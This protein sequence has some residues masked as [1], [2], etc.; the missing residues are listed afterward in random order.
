MIVKQFIADLADRGVQIHIDRNNLHVNAP[1]GVIN[2]KIKKQLLQYKH[3]IIEH[4]LLSQPHAYP[5]KR[6]THRYTAP[7]SYSQQRLWFI[8][9]KHEPDSSTYNMLAVLRIDGALNTAALSNAFL[10]L[11]SRHSSLRTTFALVDGKPMQRV[12]NH[13]F[14]EI[15]VIDIKDKQ[16]LYYL[17]AQYHHVFQLSKGPLIKVKLLRL[18]V[19]NYILLINIH[20]IICDGWSMGV[21]LHELSELYRSVI[22]MQPSSLARL[23][24]QYVDFS[25]WQRQYLQGKN[26]EQQLE[27]WKSQ[28]VG[29]PCVLELPTDKPRSGSHTSAGSSVNFHIAES[30]QSKLIQLSQ[31]YQCTLF[32]TLL[33]AFKLLLARYSG[34]NDICIGTPIANRQ[35][36][37][38]ENLIGFFTNTLVIRSKIRD[39]ISFIDLLHDL[40]KT[41]LN[42][43]SNQDVPFDQIVKAV[44]PN[45]NEHYSALF[46]VSFSLVNEPLDALSLPGCTISNV[47]SPATTSPFDLSITVT[48]SKNTLTGFAQYRSGLFYRSTIDQLLSCYTLLLDKIVQQ[49]LA[50]LADLSLLSWAD[51]QKITTQ[52]NRT[53][54]QANKTGIVHQWFEQ[55]VKHSP[56]ALAVTD[57]QQTINYQRLNETSNQLARYLLAHNTGSEVRVG[58]CLEN[59]VELIIAIIAI[60]KAGAVYVP[61]D[62]S[63][64]ENR[65]RYI[66]DDSNCRLFLTETSFEHLSTSMADIETIC[67]DVDW[68]LITTHSDNNPNQA[69]KPDNLAYIIY[70]SGSTG[71]PKGVMITQRAF[72][73]HI[74]WM[75]K[76]FSLD[77][78]DRVLQKTP[79]IFDAACSEW[80]ATLLSGAQLFMP[81]THVQKNPQQLLS[82]IHSNQISYLHI[83]PSLLALLINHTDCQKMRSLRVIEVGG[84]LFP[85]RVHENISRKLPDTMVYHVYG[86]TE[87]TIESTCWQCTDYTPPIAVPIG[88]ANDNVLIYILDNQQNLAPIGAKGQLYIGGEGLARGY[89]KKPDLTAE[90]FIPN[91]FGNQRGARLYKTGDFARY[92]DDGNIMFIGRADHQVQLRGL[93]IELGE[94]ENALLSHPMIEQA[95]VIFQADKTDTAKHQLNAF[96]TCADHHCL[97]SIALRE[98]LLG[99][100]PDYMLPNTFTFC[101]ELPRTT[102]G[103]IDRRAI[104]ENL[105]PNPTPQKNIP[106]LPMS[107][108][109]A[110][111]I[112][113]WQKAL[114]IDLEDINDNFFELGGH[115]LLAGQLV[116]CIN[117]SFGTSLSIRDLFKTPTIELLAIAIDKQ[118]VALS[119]NTSTV[120]YIEEALPRYSAMLSLPQQRVI[121]C[122]CKQPDQQS[123]WNIPWFLRLEGAINTALLEQSLQF[124]VL[125]HQ[126][127]RTAFQRREDSYS[128][129]IKDNATLPFCTIDIA[130]SDLFYYLTVLR[131]HLFDM[132]HAPLI[133]VVLL[134]LSKTTH[135]LSINMHHIIADGYSLAILFKELGALYN[136]GLN[137]QAIS[138]APLP[139]TYT[140]FT[141]WQ[142]RQIERGKTIEHMNY[143]REYLHQVNTNCTFTNRAIDQQSY[144]TPHFETCRLSFSTQLYNNLIQLSRAQHCTLFVSLITGFTLLLSQYS[145][146]EDVC[147]LFD[148]AN[149]QQRS[150]HNIIGFFANTLLLRT[151]ITNNSES[152]VELLRRV[153]STVLAISDHQ[154]IAFDQML[155]I[156]EPTHQ[157]GLAPIFQTAFSLQNADYISLTLGSVAAKTISVEP[158][159]IKVDL[160]VNLIESTSGLSGEIVFSTDKFTP[161]FASRLC[162]EYI[163]LLECIGQYPNTDI[164][165]LRDTQHQKVPPY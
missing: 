63:F 76:R 111:L 44:N 109:Q 1:S 18:S 163:K 9:Q 139:Y 153:Q 40:K 144:V 51:Y 29:A 103:K 165:K 154:D 16:L 100:L 79:L 150:F 110:T 132:D 59:S 68:A 117:E 137:C 160:G 85:T 31:T 116:S 90:R 75:L 58:L 74:H 143:W 119:A 62:P 156:A 95:V 77:H 7:L 158:M 121:N 24:C 131:S 93:R 3:Q 86:T 71:K 70:T 128:I 136:A 52:W 151:R 25:I 164:N 105:T 98:Y 82:L 81:P 21:L 96:V 142:H 108:T 43:Y 97:N 69:I 89:I 106:S 83:V 19:S 91:P 152:F 11:V 84:E 112:A 115:S 67:I 49:P 88:R 15:P 56:D 54:S 133:K 5:I 23:P 102:T 8:Q 33:A 4:I 27:Y 6:S 60:L 107:S 157:K 124:L 87:T 134:R 55:Q 73:N 48:Q 135:I 42:A 22:H 36:P 35:H 141:H 140:D 32:M 34:Q 2:A 99:L 46:Q 126:S 41:T 123:L 101:T 78:N 146:Q 47:D 45:R 159:P 12:N 155:S 161:H 66:L 65:V 17:S 72:F 10:Q 104:A 162:N 50:R 129:T 94:I 26:R 120:E 127:L 125:R 118:L 37:N 30:L 57:F 149:R 38:V 145:A 138:L 122:I 61:I 28:L 130:E 92:T 80:A 13:L 39:D 147:I 20:H 114:G 53:A 148:E 14:A 113:I 64:P